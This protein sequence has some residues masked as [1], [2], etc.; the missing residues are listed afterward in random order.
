MDEQL[1]VGFFPTDSPQGKD[2]LEQITALAK[3]WQLDLEVFPLAHG[4]QVLWQCRNKDIVIF[5]ASVETEGRSNYVAVTGEL[6]ILHHVLIVSRT[7]LPL[8]LLEARPGGYPDYPHSFSNEQIIAWLTKEIADI[9]SSGKRPRDWIGLKTWNTSWNLREERLHAQGHVFI[10]YRGSDAE[11]VKV[12]KLRIENGDFHQGEKKQALYFPP[13]MLSL[14]VM[15]EQR[16]WQIV[17]IIR[18]HLMMADEVWIYETKSVYYNSWWTLAEL[19]TLAYM[20]NNHKVYLYHPETQS[21]Q[22]A[23]DD[24][25]QP[26]TEQ[27]RTRA[28]RWFANCTP[29]EMGP[30]AVMVF[31]RFREIPLINRINF[32]KD[33]VWSEEFWHYPVLDCPRCRTIGQASNRYNVDDLLFTRGLHFTKLTPEEM[34]HSL[35]KGK[36]ICGNPACKADY[37]IKD[38]DPHYLWI[39]PGRAEQIA[40]FMQ[41]TWTAVDSFLV[42]M[43]TYLIGSSDKKY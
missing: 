21:V 3:T 19:L 29:S 15:T 14:E 11:A 16:R 27:Q 9:Q 32:V 43:P 4:G 12:L 36:I 7:Y 6:T 33:H 31:R 22:K 34:Q 18:D 40:A 20:R 13:G 41:Y 1:T 25:L 35:Q 17:S 38:S 30:E 10:S 26:L 23:P 28:A 39:P 8:N 37:E 2:L 42:S 24:Y 5:D